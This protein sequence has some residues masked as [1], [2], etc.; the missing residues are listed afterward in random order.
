[1]EIQ[2]DQILFTTIEEGNKETY[3]QT[4]Y[5]NDPDIINRLTKASS[6]NENHKVAVADEANV[7]FFFISG[8]EFVEMF[9]G[10]GSCEGKGS[11]QTG[12]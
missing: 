10:N 12:S 1:V 3:Y 5:I 6:P 7:P 8:S 4:G 11:V 9:R 2:D